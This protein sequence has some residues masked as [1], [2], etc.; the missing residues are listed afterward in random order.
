MSIQALF[1]GLNEPQPAARIRALYVLAMVEEV[2]ALPVLRDMLRWETHP[3][4]IEEIKRTGRMLAEAQKRGHTTDAAIRAQF[5]LHLEEQSAAE[6]EEEKKLAQART[7]AELQMIR[8]QGSSTGERG[9]RTGSGMA[10]AAGALLVGGASYSASAIA[11]SVSGANSV[12]ESNLG[13]R[14]PQIGLQA[15][16]PQRPSDHDISIWL[17]RLKDSDPDKRKTALIELKGLNNPG[18][19][20]HLAMCYSS[21]PEQTLREEAQKV[22]KSIYYNWLHWE[23][24]EAAKATQA[25]PQVSAFGTS[26]ATQA[27]PGVQPSASTGATGALPQTGKL[28][29]AASEADRQ[30]IA[31]MLER[32]RLKRQA[33]EQQ[34]RR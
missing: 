14:R 25:V 27:T 28:S 20:P 10:L 16:P 15:I 5:R 30:A 23:R 9:G 18:A 7:Q 29:E 2:E 21:D 3:A 11:S 8:D 13:Q 1:I 4:V 33:R 12:T 26:D 24:T 19:L 32:A 22:G 34:K 6:S 31:D 17:K